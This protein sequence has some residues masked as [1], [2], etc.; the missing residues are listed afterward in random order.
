[1]CQLIACRSRL[2]PLAG[3]TYC[4]WTVLRFN[5]HIGRHPTWFVEC[6]CGH[7]SIARQTDLMRGNSTQCRSCARYKHGY[8]F[9]GVAD[10]TYVTWAD[11][12]QRC[13]A[14]THKNYPDYGGRG[15]KMCQGWDSFENFLADMGERPAGL[16]IDRIGNDG[17]YSCGHCQECLKNGWAANCRWATR[18]DQQRNRR[19][20]RY[21]EYHG[22]RMLL[23]E[24][25]ERFG[26]N[27]ST[28]RYR[29]A[30]GWSVEDALDTPVY[31]SHTH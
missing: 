4:K 1:M 3:N 29:L 21:V 15:I 5:T 30:R 25:A 8:A 18:R 23:V 28:I 17:H 20:N 27:Y 26:I 9:R 22:E 10:P 7:R 11:A 31:E 13:N 16:T 12:R 2:E 19:D 24:A 6:E 14:P